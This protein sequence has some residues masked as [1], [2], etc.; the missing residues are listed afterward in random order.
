MTELLGAWD[1]AGCDTEIEGEAKVVCV[2]PAEITFSRLSESQDLA[3]WR[4]GWVSAHLDP[5]C[6]PG[7][8]LGHKWPHS[9]APLRCQCLPQHWYPSVMEMTCELTRVQHSTF[10]LAS[11]A[12]L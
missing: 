5:Q 12:G 3:S 4:S 7:C 6:S 2:V 8:C 9:A 11:W 10:L 1:P